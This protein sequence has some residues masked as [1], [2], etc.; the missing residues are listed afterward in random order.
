MSEAR[1]AMPYVSPEIRDYGRL[2]VLTTFDGGLHFSQAAVGSLTGGGGST[3]PG[4]T[5]TTTPGQNVLDN[6]QSG[7]TTTPDVPDTSGVKDAGS[8]GPGSS[9][10]THVE[11]GSDS[12]GGGLGSGGESLPFTG[13][14]LAP[15]AA[16]GA[17]LTA[18]GA[19]LRRRIR[20][21]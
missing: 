6:T 21:P 16:L 11:S 13:L 14:A 20:R 19:T 9:P 8:S 10:G 4:T 18:A 3:P 5:T 7:G 2:S 15:V 12:G 1:I 17:G